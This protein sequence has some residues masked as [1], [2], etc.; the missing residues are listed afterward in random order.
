[1]SNTE[2]YVTEEDN[3][4]FLIQPVGTDRFCGYTKT[5]GPSRRATRAQAVDVLN[6]AQRYPGGAQWMVREISS[7]D[8]Y[9]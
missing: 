1:M 6:C 9:I 3:M 2:K 8:S 7:F 4:W 5:T